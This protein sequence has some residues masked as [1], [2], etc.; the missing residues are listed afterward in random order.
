MQGSEEVM[1]EGNTYW[2]GKMTNEKAG[3]YHCIAY[4]YWTYYYGTFNVIVGGKYLW[5]ILNKLAKI[6]FERPPDE[7]SQDRLVILH[8]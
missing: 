6:G 8:S 2:L 7:I 5:A 1:E 4:T 3:L